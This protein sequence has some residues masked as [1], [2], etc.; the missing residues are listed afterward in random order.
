MSGTTPQRL[1]PQSSP[2]RPWPDC[3][4]SARKSAPASRAA[5]DDPRHHV[6]LRHEDAVR[7]EGRVDEQRR[8]PAAACRQPLNGASD[9]GPTDRRLVVRIGIAA[10]VG[11]G[12]REG[13]HAGGLLAAR[14]LRG[15]EVGDRGGDAVVRPLGDEA[16]IGSGEG[17]RQ[18]PG[19]VIGLRAGVDEHHRVEAV[20]HR[21]H[22]ALG[23][24]DDVFVEIARVGVERRGL[25]GDGVDNPRVSVPDHRHVVVG[26][27]VAAAVGGLHPGARTADQVKRT[28]IAQP[29]E[30]RA[31]H[32]LPSRQERV[33]ALAVR[34]GARAIVASRSPASPKP[35][36]SSCSSSAH[37]GSD[38]PWM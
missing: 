36:A 38:Q 25:T 9:F 34:I 23:Q 14:P 10:T 27:E 37:A 13:L 22:Q 32:R 26:V 4:S 15:R 8:G 1:K 31:K 7:G 28:P 3:T 12:S 6:R 19:E 17:R 20:G 2:V 11:V 24:L 21:C 33:V 18:A 35:I 5:P 30:R 16:R 29:L